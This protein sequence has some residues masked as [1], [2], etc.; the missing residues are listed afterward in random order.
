M[1]TMAAARETVPVS[2]RAA[3]KPRCRSGVQPSWRYLRA[4]GWKSGSGSA[5]VIGVRFFMIRDANRFG[6]V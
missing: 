2:A 6:S 5:R 4:T 1:L 3:M